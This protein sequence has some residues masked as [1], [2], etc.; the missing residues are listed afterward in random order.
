MSRVRL[1][2][3][4]SEWE[5]ELEGLRLLVEREVRVGSCGWRSRREWYRRECMC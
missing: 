1:W 5:R 2:E 4:K 3:I